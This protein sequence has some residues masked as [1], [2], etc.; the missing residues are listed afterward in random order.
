[1]SLPRRL[2]DIVVITTLYPSELRPHEGIFAER[3]W[4][5]MTQRGHRVRVLHPQPFAPPSFLPGIPEAWR[6]SSRMAAQELRSGLLVSR[7]RYLHVP[8]RAVGNAG[9]L[10]KRCLASLPPSAKVDV[11]VLD[12]AW[13]AAACVA[14]LTSRGVPTVVSGR[15]SDILQVAEIQDLRRELQAALAQATSYC[16]VSHD[17][18]GVMDE[19]SGR[20]GAGRLVPNGVDTTGFLPAQREPA[21]ASLGIAAEGPI[22]LVVGHLIERKDPILA[23]RAFASGA[24]AQA[25]LYFVGRGPLQADLEREVHKLGLD[26]RVVL[27]GERPPEELARWY[28]AADLLLLTSTREG[29]PNVVLEALASGRP[30]LAT[31]S[32]GT[33]ELPLSEEMLCD[34]RDPQVL[35]RALELILAKNYEAEE[36]AARAAPYS[37]EASRVA[38]E[39]LLLEA[40]DR[41][42]DWPSA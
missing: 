12:Y 29:R 13:P 42:C 32:G 10:A 40:V 15:G 38:L 24:A 9:R 18:V 30:V 31:P 7:P 4:I 5:G 14:G 35:G 11:C 36:I 1:M 17:L 25:R 39:E 8:G 41:G 27:C 19:L 16:A 2:L 22:V 6:E 28:A 33:A 23:L 37:W 26:G 3:R 34:S 21:R 20:A